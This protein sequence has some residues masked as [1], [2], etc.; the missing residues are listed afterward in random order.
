MSQ[1]TN[2]GGRVV[3]IS[4]L[5]RC[6]IEACLQ[7]ELQAEDAA[8]IAELLLNYELRGHASHGV[9]LVGFLIDSH[10]QR[11]LNPRP[12]VAVI[13]ET[14]STLLLD[15]DRSYIVAAVRAMR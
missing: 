11:S 7:L 6:V 2:D 8:Q 14:D 4:D 9:H 12:R 1:S 15:G 5:R 3:R 10:R 13:R